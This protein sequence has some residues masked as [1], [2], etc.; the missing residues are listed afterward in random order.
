MKTVYI[1]PQL[2]KV[3]MEGRDIL[4]TSTPDGVHNEYKPGEGLA[5]ERQR[6]WN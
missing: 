2:S 1:S 3:M 4:T 5:P 6:I